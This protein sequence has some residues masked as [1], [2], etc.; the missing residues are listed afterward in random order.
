MD[1]EIFWGGFWNAFGLWFSIGI[2]FWLL[3]RIFIRKLSS[4]TGLKAP[5]LKTHI[6]CPDCKEFILKDALICKHCRFRFDTG[7]DNDSI[8]PKY[9]TDN[10]N[11]WRKHDT[12]SANDEVKEIGADI[13][14]ASVFPSTT[15]LKIPEQNTHTSDAQPSNKSP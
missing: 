1:T 12:D 5:S 2:A 13:N 4:A 9:E 14:I 11:F 7:R 3:S 8:W 10:D 6:K 15:E